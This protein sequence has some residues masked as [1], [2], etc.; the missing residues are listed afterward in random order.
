MGWCGGTEIA[1]RMA[2][3]VESENIPILV[4]I[5]LLVDLINCLEDHDWD[6][7]DEVDSDSIAWKS[8]VKHVHPSWFA[9]GEG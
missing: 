6:N 9:E 5:S 3:A 7:I 8:A 1:E 2:K 4:K